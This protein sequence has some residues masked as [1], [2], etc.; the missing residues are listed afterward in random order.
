VIFYNGTSSK[1]LQQGNGYAD[2]ATARKRHQE[3]QRANP[4]VPTNVPTHIPRTFHNMSPQP[5]GGA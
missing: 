2:Q 4:H 1:K 3:T 5:V